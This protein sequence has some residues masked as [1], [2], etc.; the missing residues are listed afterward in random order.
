[1]DAKER[2][3]KKVKAELEKSIKTLVTES[4]KCGLGELIFFFHTLHFM[5]LIPKRDDLPDNQREAITMMAQATDEACKYIVQCVVKYGHKQFLF[6]SNRMVIDGE[7][8]R[9]MLKRATAINSGFEMLYFIKR[10]SKVEVSGVRDQDIKMNIEELADLS[11]EVGKFWLYGAR[12]E[13]NTMLKKSGISKDDILDRFKKEYREIEHLFVKV[14]EVSIDEFVNLLDGLMTTVVTS[15]E[16]AFPITDTEEIDMQLYGNILKFGRCYLL[17]K[18]ELIGRLSVKERGALNLLIFQP[19]KFDEHELRFN[20]LAR[21]PLFQVGSSLIVSPELILDSISLNTHFSMLEASE[22]HEQYKTIASGKFLDKVAGVFARYAY[23][24]IYR[25]YDL[26]EGKNQIGDI[27]IGFKNDAGRIILVEAKN[28]FLPLEVYFRDTDAVKSRLMALRNDWEKK[29][30][31]RNDHL[32]NNFN[33]YSLPENFEYII[34]TRSPEILTHFSE[35][36]VFDLYELDRYLA[37]FARLTSVEEI[38]TKIYGLDEEEAEKHDL[39]QLDYFT[40]GFTF[41]KE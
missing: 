24:E 33:R 41:T 30:T 18:D 27:D 20:R 28:H 16:K 2:A 10:I 14:F 13:R 1:M 4:R 8:C 25:E 19:G 12:V 22:I 31:K 38:I 35:F 36:K 17:D 6:T 29:V 26:F 5:R 11:T 9:A 7:R 34:V 15:V 23:A 39:S 40:P 3:L 21:Q 37:D 32:K